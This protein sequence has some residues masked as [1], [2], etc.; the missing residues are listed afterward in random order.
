MSRRYY[1]LMLITLP[2]FVGIYAHAQ[3]QYPLME[4]V[5]QK[6]VQKY[7]QSSCQE[8]AQQKSQPPT[9]QEAQMMQNAV[10]ILHENPDMREQFINIVAAPIANKL[11]ECGMIP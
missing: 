11:F 8:L 9:G 4:K 7:Q 2:L 5:A 6:V 3:S 10:K 1:V